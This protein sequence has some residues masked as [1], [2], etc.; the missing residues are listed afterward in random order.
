MG[1][2]PFRLTKSELITSTPRKCEGCWRIPIEAEDVLQEVRGG[3]LTEDQ[4]RAKFA[5]IGEQCLHGVV[6]EQRTQ[7]R[8]CTN[9]VL[10]M[11]QTPPLH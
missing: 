11:D 10:I 4:A 1:L 6:L 2:S 7:E 9:P 5:A 3:E 8:I